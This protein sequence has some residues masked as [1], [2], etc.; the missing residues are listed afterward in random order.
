MKDKLTKR[1]RVKIDYLALIK[2]HGLYWV[3]LRWRKHLSPKVKS[4]RRQQYMFCM[5]YLYSD[6]KDY[7]WWNANLDEMIR[8]AKTP[9]L[10]ED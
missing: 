9:W 5:A 4:K 6:V 3:Y 7:V 8:I 1:K 10:D 2:G